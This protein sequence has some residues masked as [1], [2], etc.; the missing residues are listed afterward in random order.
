MDKFRSCIGIPLEI[1][2][3]TVDIND[4]EENLRL[5]KTKIQGIHSSFIFNLDKSGYS[6]Y[7]DAREKKLIVP[8][9]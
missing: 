5:L 1:D 9:S 7:A 6:E 3:L 2:R 4:I 8:V